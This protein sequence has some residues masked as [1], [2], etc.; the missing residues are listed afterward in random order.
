MKKVIP[1]DSIP[2]NDKWPV[3]LLNVLLEARKSKNSQQLN[4]NKKQL[5]DMIESLCIS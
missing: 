1:I 4:L 2:D 5:D 3:N